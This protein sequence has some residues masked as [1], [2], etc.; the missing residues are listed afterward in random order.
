MCG[1]GGSGDDGGG[2]EGGSK[3]RV[4][5]DA[6]TGE[7]DQATCRMERS[8]EA[9]LVRDQMELF[10]AQSQVRLSRYRR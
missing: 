4:D 7:V 8:M 2:D 9:Y 10:A 6:D 3:E 1:S 5:S